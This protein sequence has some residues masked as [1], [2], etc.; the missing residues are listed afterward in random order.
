[1][2]F[3]QVQLKENLEM[4][5]I[6]SYEQILKLFTIVQGKPKTPALPWHR[7]SGQK[8]PEIMYVSANSFGAYYY[9]LG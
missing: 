3:K 7:T 6:R 4:W 8:D 5:Q 1:M 2:L 9:M